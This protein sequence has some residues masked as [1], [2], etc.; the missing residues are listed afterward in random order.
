MEAW[1]H[2]SRLTGYVYLLVV[3]ACR[4]HRQPTHY[5]ITNRYKSLFPSYNTNSDCKFEFY[6]K[7]YVGISLVRL[8]TF[9]IF[10]G[11]AATKK[12]L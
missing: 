7:F 4:L 1:P 9:I 11:A 3:H 10:A 5:Y 6:A 2:V 12:K 8:L